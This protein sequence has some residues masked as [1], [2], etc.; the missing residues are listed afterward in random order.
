V[1]KRALYEVGLFCAC[2]GCSCDDDGCSLAATPSISIFCRF[3]SF[4]TMSCHARSSKSCPRCNHSIFVMVT[5]SARWI[6]T[7]VSLSS[8]DEKSW[9]D[10]AR[11]RGRTDFPSSHR[12]ASSVGF[13]IEGVW[14]VGGGCN[15]ML[16]SCA[17]MDGSW[18]GEGRVRWSE[19]WACID[20][21]SEGPRRWGME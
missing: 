17:E 15:G 19:L 9:S 20:D 14:G 11:R 3:F 4:A 12:F 18:G 8:D 16:L 5:F 10:F 21:G 1:S 13:F 7:G 2:C 6:V